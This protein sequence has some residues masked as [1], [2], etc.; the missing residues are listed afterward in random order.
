MTAS[1]V[2]EVVHPTRAKFP[3]ILG[4]GMSE[5]FIVVGTRWMYLVLLQSDGKS[6]GDMQCFVARRILKK[7]NL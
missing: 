3:I 4:E 6:H 7:K 2:T 5:L 1:F